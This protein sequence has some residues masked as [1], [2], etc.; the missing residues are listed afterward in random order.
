MVPL[1]DEFNL[2]SFDSLSNMVFKKSLVSFS[3]RP[4]VKNPISSRNRIF[5]NVFTLFPVLAEK[6]MNCMVDIAVRIHPT[7]IQP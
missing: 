5:F 4:N 7:S 6:S 2:F 3:Y 1:H